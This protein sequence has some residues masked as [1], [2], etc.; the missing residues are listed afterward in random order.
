[1]RPDLDHYMMTLAEVAATR[2]TCIKRGV[3]CV[4]ADEAGHVLSIGYNGVA[5]GMPHCNQP[6][7]EQDS[8]AAGLARIVFESKGRSA[9]RS[10]QKVQVYEYACKDYALPS[11]QDSCEAIHAEQN[12]LIQCRDVSLISTAYVTLSPCKPC[13][14]LLINTGCRRIVFK[15]LHDDPWPGEQWQKLGRIWERL[16]ST[17]AG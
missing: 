16:S 9:P 13:L 3:G 5:R 1:M 10:T 8:G 7:G 2:T 15:A 12:A 6:T 11:G 4:L 14:K 17:P